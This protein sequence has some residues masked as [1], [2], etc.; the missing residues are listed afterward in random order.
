MECPLR[1]IIWNV[2]IYL[3]LL[4]STIYFQLSTFYFLLSHDA[5][6]H[7]GD[8]RWLRFATP[9][10]PYTMPCAIIALATFINPA[11]LAPLT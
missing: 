3:H 11:M 7:H 4:H 6:R 8:K 1:I 2:Y 10:L 5:L 9:K